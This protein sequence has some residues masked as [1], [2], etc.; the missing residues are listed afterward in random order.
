MMSIVS[1]KVFLFVKK[2]HSF[3]S[4]K[5]DYEMLAFGIMCNWTKFS[6]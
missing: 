3:S 4:L 1:F 5:H 6:Y 2:C